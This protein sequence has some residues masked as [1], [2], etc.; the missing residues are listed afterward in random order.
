MEFTW[1]PELYDNKHDFVAKYG[2]DLVNLLNPKQ[3]EII[4]DLGYGTGDLTKKISGLCKMVVGLDNSSSMIQAAQKKYPGITFLKADAK[5]FKL[6]YNFDAVFSNAVL[7]WIPEAETVIKNIS[8]HLRVGG[9]F[10]AD[11][12]GIGCVK[13]IINTLTDIFNEYKFIYPK[14]ED[15]L[16]YPSISQ[17]TP[18]LEQSGFEVNLA[19]LFD[20]PT[21]LN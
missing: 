6:D 10:V 11:F 14:I 4:L 13:K 17:Y 19:V 3:N 1:N 8:A 18:L 20:R 2:E 5:N 21:K 12:G 15:S 16:Y 7:H 9:R